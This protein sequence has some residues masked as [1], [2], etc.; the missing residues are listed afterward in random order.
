MT[1]LAKLRAYAMRYKAKLAFGLACIVMANLFRAA[2]PILLQQAIDALNRR[3]TASALFQY[4][5]LVIACALIQG[6]FLFGHERLLLGMVR[7]VEQ[8]MRNDFYAHLQKMPLE[9]FQLNRTGDLMARATSDLKEAASAASQFVSYSVNTIVALLVIVP[10]MVSINWRLTVLVFIPLSLLVLAGQFLQ[11]RIRERTEQTQKAF[12]DVSSRVQETLSSVRTIRA[13]TQEDAEIANFRSASRQ[14][15]NH[16][17]KLIQLTGAFHPAV[18]FL[19]GMSAIIVLW[20]G[21]S[22]IS[23]GKLSV[24]Q[25]VEFTLYIGYLVAPMH[26]LGWAVTVIQRGRVSMER[27]HSIMTMEP[28]IR[29]PLLPA[30]I[31]AIRGEIEFRNV[32]FTYPGSVRPALDGINLRISSGETVALVGA[33][34]SGKSTLMNMIPRLL[35]AQLGKVLMDGHP[36][37]DLSL[38]LLR[39]SIGCIP[40]ESFL[41][42]GAIAANIAFGVEGASPEEIEW[43]AMQAGVAEDIAEFTQGYDTHIGERGATL[44]GGQKQRISIARALLRRPGILL[45][46]DAL[47][48]VDASTEENILNHLQKLN[49]GR[50]CVISSHR[51]STVRGA[52]RIV[53]LREGRIA[54]QGPPAELLANNGLYAEMYQRQMVEAELSA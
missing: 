15:T 27:L 37:Q 45:L 25:F 23:Q 36:V 44:S 14:Y 16:K 19:V 32:H 22:L 54:E 18:Q 53:V 24:G 48:S 28:A 3:I 49:R 40:Q 12:S 7:D 50:T 9:F 46:D 38:R 13:Y 10:V 8:D 39:S 35:D 5:G 29:D 47:A 34:G 1:A 4:S 2:G 41:F 26:D 20:Y 31:A 11:K 21:G 33:V 30:E 52:D 43:A 17:V 6:G 51:A 42:S